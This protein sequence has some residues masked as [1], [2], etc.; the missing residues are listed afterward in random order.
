MTENDIK[1]GCKVTLLEWPP[2]LN[3]AIW[4]FA[5]IY[6]PFYDFEKSGHTASM[7]PLH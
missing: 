2:S 6:V 5:L 1:L 3:A 7:H 4:S